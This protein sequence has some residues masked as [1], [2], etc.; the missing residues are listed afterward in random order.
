MKEYPSL[1][2]LA[3]GFYAKKFGFP[4][5]VQ[6]A[7]SEQ[8]KISIFR[9]EVDLSIILSLA[10]KIDSIFSFFSSKKKISG[11]GDPFGIRRISISLIKILTENKLDLDLLQIFNCC[12][13]LNL[14]QKIQSINDLEL[15]INF[16][17]KRIEVFF[18]DEGYKAEVIKSCLNSK[19]FNPFFIL[20][21]NKEF[22]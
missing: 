5:D 15:I 1:Q 20:S 6:D 14:E 11:S 12:Q 4:K 7:F 18:I 10:Q 21:K 16:L 3:G 19:S 22:N 13:K 8:Y 9:K 2:G 17:N